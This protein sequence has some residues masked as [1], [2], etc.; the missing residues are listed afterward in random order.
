MRI[1]KIHNRYWSVCKMANIWQFGKRLAAVS[2]V[3]LILWIYLSSSHPW[4]SVPSTRLV[5]VYY[6]SLIWYV[7]C[8]ETL[9]STVEVSPSKPGV[10]WSAVW[11][12][13]VLVQFGHSLALHVAVGPPVPV[14]ILPWTCH[15]PSGE[16]ATL[17]SVCSLATFSYEDWVLCP[18]LFLILSSMPFS[19]I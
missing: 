11:C 6:V 19:G 9:C 2:K 10:L 7:P 1:E 5:S 18:I 4:L 15:T 3:F 16:D 12:R 17:V 14:Q 8:S 13:C